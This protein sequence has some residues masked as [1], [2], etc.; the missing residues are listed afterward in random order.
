MEPPGRFVVV[1]LGLG[2]RVQWPPAT[3]PRATGTMPASVCDSRTSRQARKRKICSCRWPRR[4]GDWPNK[5]RARKS[6]TPIELVALIRNEPEGYS[7]QHSTEQERQ[8]PKISVPTLDDRRCRQ[9]IFLISYSWSDSQF[10]FLDEHRIIVV[11]ARAVHRLCH[12]SLLQHVIERALQQPDNHS[13]QP[14]LIV[15]FGTPLMPCC[16]SVTVRSGHRNHF[17]AAGRSCLSARDF[18][19]RQSPDQPWMAGGQA[20]ARYNL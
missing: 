6:R 10:D 13:A 12:R 8:N 11:S 4:G 3:N 20:F 15:L 17:S 9:A 2:G 19:S 16:E 5:P 18:P 1:A 14:R 7:R